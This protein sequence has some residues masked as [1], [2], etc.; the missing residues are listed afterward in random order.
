MKANNNWL[1]WAFFYGTLAGILFFAWRGDEFAAHAF[2]AVMWFRIVAVLVACFAMH[3]HGRVL[4]AWPRSWCFAG[5]ILAAELGVWW[6][7]WLKGLSLELVFTA[8]VL[9][10]Y[11]DF[12]RYARATN[13]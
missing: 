7:M 4:A 5:A 12:R 11:E 2:R 3:P 1:L 6:A 13:P 10:V 8:L 9:L